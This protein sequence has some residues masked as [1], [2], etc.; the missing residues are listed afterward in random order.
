MPTTPVRPPYDAELAALLDNSPLPT[1]VTADMIGF[2]RANPFGPTLDDLVATRPITHAEYKIPGPAGDLVAS[3]FTPTDSEE[4]AP[5]I[6]HLHGGGMI[7][8]NR[9]TGISHVLDWAVEHGAVVVSLEYRL[10]PETTAPGPVE[11]AYAGL[12]WLAAN[13]SS[14]GV[15]AD[16]I[17]ITGTSAGAGLAAG[18]TLLSRDRRGPALIAQ[19][20]LSP[21]IDDRG[22]TA[23]SRQYTQTGSWSRESNDTGWTA[24]LGDR[25]GTSG[26]D[27]YSAPSRAIDLT[28]LPPAFID[29]GSA[30]VFRD[31]DVAYATG[32]WAH[33]V[34]AELH[35]WAGG[36]HIFDG[37][38]PE[39]R[40]SLAAVAARDSWMIRT[41][42]R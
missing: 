12:V 20:L 34:Q 22:T 6:Y 42:G 2:L 7:L 41:L 21:M 18:V 35:V 23:S 39:A 28:G 1:T 14:L 38:A 10:A 31:E 30:E 4:S 8:G 5:A 36:F 9:F 40:L 37:A 26:V 17:M 3:V 16:R 13:A 24:L 25:R 11:D 19:M 33:G 15:D 29:V 27:I 32:L